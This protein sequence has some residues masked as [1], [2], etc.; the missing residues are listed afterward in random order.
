MF[1]SHAVVRVRPKDGGVKRGVEEVRG[2]AVLSKVRPDCGFT[3]MRRGRYVGCADR[4]VFATITAGLRFGDA[5]TPIVFISPLIFDRNILTPLA[6]TSANILYYSSI[7]KRE[8]G[9]LKLGRP[10]PRPLA[11]E[12]TD[13]HLLAFRK[14]PSPSRT[15]RSGRTTD[16]DSDLRGDPAP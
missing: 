1:K 6:D 10:E 9:A 14:R 11:G 7:S 15:T 5:Q 4:R 12:G 16:D 3:D 2:G 13:L 8:D